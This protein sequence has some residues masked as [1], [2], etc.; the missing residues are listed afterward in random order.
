MIARA[1]YLLLTSAR[2]RT[3]LAPL[4]ITVFWVFGTFFYP[5]NEVGGTWGQTGSHAARWPRGWSARSW[6]ASR[7]RRRR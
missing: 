1:R 3:P 5:N 2:T 4:A 7:R 6:P